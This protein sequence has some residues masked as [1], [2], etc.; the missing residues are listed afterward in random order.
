MMR[1]RTRPPG[2][3]LITAGSA[4]VRS[5]ARKASYLTSFRSGLAA[6]PAF[7]MS[8]IDAFAGTGT[9]PLSQFR[10]YLVGR[11]KAEIGQLDDNLLLIGSVA[12]IMDDE[13]R[14][15]QQLFL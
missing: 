12:P 2:S 3:T 6:A 8:A 1:N 11:C 5:L 7:G 15:H 9:V 10:K 4:S 14:C 13:W